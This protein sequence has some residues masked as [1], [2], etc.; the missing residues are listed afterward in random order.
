MFN[1]PKIITLQLDMKDTVPYKLF[2]DLRL[3]AD[4]FLTMLR[5][6][7]AEIE[8]LHR[9]IDKQH[10]EIKEYDNAQSSSLHNP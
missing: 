7:D 8:E 2:R 5:S 1:F 4:H 6:R 3:E 10:Q 9:I